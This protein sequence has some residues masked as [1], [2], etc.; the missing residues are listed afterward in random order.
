MPKTINVAIEEGLHGEL[1]KISKVY[2]T[3]INWLVKRSICYALMNL[4]KSFGFTEN[5]FTEPKNE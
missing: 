2:G 5:K 4:E 1:K 3:N